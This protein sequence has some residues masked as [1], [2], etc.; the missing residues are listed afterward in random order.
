VGY[1]ISA[2]FLSNQLAKA[3]W[4]LTGIALAFDV[5]S[6]RALESRRLADLGPDEDETG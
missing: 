5:M 1:S 6:R 3:L 2:V 4:I